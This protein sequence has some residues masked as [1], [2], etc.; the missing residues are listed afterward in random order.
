MSRLN[1]YFYDI[2]SLTNAFT[3]SCYRPDDQRVDIYYIVDDPALNE[4]DSLDFKKAAAQ[5]IREKNQNFTGEIYYYNLRTSSAS[6]RLAQTFGVSDAQYVNDP[7][8][9]S[10]F[11][12]QFR[13]VCDTDAGYQEEEA[14]YLMGYNSSN[15]D[16]TML[17]YY[18]TQAWQPG[19]SGKRDR[20]SAVTAR[21][22]RDFNDELFSGY[23]GNMRLR[24][25]QDKT[26]G[27]VAKNFQMSGRHIDVAQL[28]ERQRRVGLKRLLGMLGW[29]ILE[30]DKLKPGQD[31][32]TSP[33]ELADLI[34]Y[35]VSDVVNLKE[36][37]CHPYYQ[38][39]FILKKGL[40]GQYP[41]L[42]YQEDGDSYQ[43]KIG[44]AFVRKDRLTID[45][46]SANFARR[47]ICPYGRLKDDRAVSFLYPAAS[48]AEKTGEKQ[49]DIL[50]ES[51]DFFYKLFED[52]NLRQKFDRVYDYYK[53]F[54]GKNFN[55]SKEYREDYG[56]QALPVSDLSEVENEDTNLFYYQKDGQPSTCYI[57][58]SVGGLHGS[59]YNRDL[60][61][62]DH[63]LWEKKQADLAYV[64]KL[65]PDP[66]DLRKAREVT[67][68]DGRVEKYQTFLTAKATIK[69]MEQTDPADRG[70][71]WRNFSQ[72][73]PTVFKKQGSR[74]RLDDRYAFTS[75]D[76]T[77]HED[78]TSYYPNMLRR[79]NA[80]YND[81][82]G[83]DR[84]TAI[85]ERKQELDK[86]RTD[87]QYS[88]EE[89]R[90]FNIER[91]GTKLILN[92]ATGAAD[93]REGQV[94]S[95]IRMNNRIRS[96]RIIGQLFTYMIGQAQ[97][98]AGARIVSTNT[99]GLYSVLDADLNEKILAKEAAEIGV[100]IVPEELYLVS[101]DSNNRLE[102]SPDLTKVLSASGSLACRKDT[103]PTKSLA[104]PAIIDWALSRYLLEKRTD[105]A[106]PFDRDL[107]RQILEEAE[108]AFPDPAHRLR[109]FQNVLSA[110]HSRERANCIFG[111]GDAG[112]LLILQRYNRVFIYQDGLPKTVHLYS[113][114]AK[115]LTPAMLN[116]RKRS[117]EAVIQHDQE[118]LSVLKAN[119]LGNLAKGREATVQKIPNLSPD[120]SMHVENRAV[121]LLAA[122]EQEAILHSLDYDKY[123]DL[124][125]SAY[126]KNWRN[127]TTSGPVL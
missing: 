108:E 62:Q 107:G 71:F 77:N 54:A 55:P 27:L 18:F 111:R 67:L 122:E 16:L 113:A 93:P 64:Q 115:K 56:D 75:S 116:K 30:S 46:S 23:I 100:E 86:K 94:P 65:Y 97:T 57:T 66:L 99:D 98:Y 38:G 79:L 101:K 25:W 74:V 69:L 34:A 39:Q 10:S 87:P 37:F 20:F 28:N 15:Y 11:P 50:E 127:L 19:E 61:I 9:P 32:L 110:N 2:E 24:L 92:S 41:D 124:V 58:F 40:L 118:A 114:A 43:A 95:S 112:Q 117:G 76:L 90:M 83:E 42:I 22:M 51:R 84:Y 26:M 73:E 36:L 7:Q 4:G 31:Y 48:V 52:E 70:Q 125:A 6:A 5:R 53:Q 63:A 105:L 88:A 89:R 33:E 81:R 80:F 14:P 123:L 3:L 45:S 44:S 109:M 121:N 47:T 35:N 13:P 59:E 91:E 120:W 103:S 126:E 85:F 29:Q 102:A 17:A 96:M 1:S 72:D 78:F 82:L 104:H 21:E 119:G 68:P 49:R 8:A 106:A 12:G 60:Y